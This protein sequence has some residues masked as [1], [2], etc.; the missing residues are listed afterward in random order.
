MPSNLLHMVVEKDHKRVSRGNSSTNE[1]T[2]KVLFNLISSSSMRSF[3]LCKV[4][5]HHLDLNSM[6]RI[7][8]LRKIK[9]QIL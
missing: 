1:H 5:Y 2:L 6:P 8:P 4:A 3:P 9:K 7:S